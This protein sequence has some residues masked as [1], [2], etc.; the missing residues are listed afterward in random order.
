MKR[1]IKLIKDTIHETFSSQPA[2]PIKPTF[3]FTL[4][5]VFI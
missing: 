2:F 5:P 3:I 4:L 1:N